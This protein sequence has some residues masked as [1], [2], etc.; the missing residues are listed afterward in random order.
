MARN[1]QAI[2]IDLPDQK[3]LLRAFQD[4]A[5]G[6]QRRVV[7]PAITAG[8]T[9]ATKKAKKSAPFDE[10]GRYHNGVFVEGGSLRKSLTKRVRS[11]TRSGVVMAITGVSRSFN[12]PAGI[13]PHRYLHLVND[14]T[15]E[16]VKKSTGQATGAVRPTRFLEKSMTST[17]GQQQ[18]IFRQ[19]FV[20]GMQ[21][22][23]AKYK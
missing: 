17:Q 3:K 4:L 11:F 13:E 2:S 10:E 12:H 6:S 7:R 14:G 22:L 21:R 15:K 18:S 5:G 19:K 9:P 23:A 1:N 8:H 20:A 16:R